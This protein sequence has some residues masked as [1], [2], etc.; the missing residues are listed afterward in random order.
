MALNSYVAEP[1]ST[2]Q[3]R[4]IVREL[5][6]LLKVEFDEYINVVKYL[7]VLTFIDP[8]Y[9]YQIAEDDELPETVQGETDVVNHIIRIRQSIYEKACDG[10]EYSRM[11]IAHEIGHYVLVCIE[12]ITFA[13]NTNRIGYVA[14]YKDPEWQ[15]AV[16]AS[17]FLAPSY[18]IKDLE[19][20]EISKRYG[21]TLQAASTQ[22]RHLDK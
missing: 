20:E 21:V 2:K 22:L 3:I 19:A 5:R 8:M 13:K 10:D 9:D 18:L 1:M 6:R 17:E 7:D 15:A 16:F 11:T 4:G 14:T 12:G